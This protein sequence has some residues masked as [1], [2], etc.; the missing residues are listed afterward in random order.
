VNEALS[1]V[2]RFLRESGKATR[3]VASHGQFQQIL[4]SPKPA[5]LLRLTMARDTLCIPEISANKYALNIRFLE[6]DKTGRPRMFG[7]DVEFEL[8]FCIL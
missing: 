8:T 6:P 3:H 2:L 1:I 5:Q 4:T 7:E